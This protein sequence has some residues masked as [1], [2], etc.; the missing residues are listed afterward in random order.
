[1]KKLMNLLALGALAA[2]L[3][4]AT[5]CNK[6]EE[7]KPVDEAPKVVEETTA[8][9]ATTAAPAPAMAA[10]ETAATTASTPAAPATK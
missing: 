4:V 3:V 5:G 9:T 1:M 7:T 8:T 10:T 6:A 2:T